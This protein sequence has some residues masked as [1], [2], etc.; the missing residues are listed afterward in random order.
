MNTIKSSGVTS[1]LKIIASST[2]YIQHTFFERF[3]C[4]SIKSIGN[5][6]LFR[7]LNFIETYNTNN[8]SDLL[9][10]KSVPIYNS[11][12]RFTIVMYAGEGGI[13]I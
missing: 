10:T 8:K 5:S 9:R 6:F 2:H 11:N 4:I 13:I 3:T 7:A 12:V 1:Y